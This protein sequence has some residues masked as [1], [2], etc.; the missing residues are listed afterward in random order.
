MRVYYVFQIKK[1]FLNLYFDSPNLLFSVLNQIYYMRKNDV[2]YALNL[3]QQMTERI[4]KYY[5][6]KSIF[7]KMHTC[8]RYSKK[9]DEHIINNL[10]KDEVSI[11]KIK[12]SYILINCNKEYTEFFKILKEF[13]EYFFVCDFKNH[14]Y[15][16]VNDLKILV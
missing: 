14:D 16:Y 7:I 2:N 10:Y 13:N 6:D 3:F 4:N 12:N 8:L 9:Q 1:E 5:L 11:M 15:F